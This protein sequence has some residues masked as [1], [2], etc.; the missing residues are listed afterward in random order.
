MIEALKQPGR[1]CWNEL[2][3]ND[4]AA[5]QQFYGEM[6]GWQME[7]TECGGVAYTTLKVNNDDIGGIMKT[8]AEAGEMPPM[9]GGYVTVDDVDESAANATQLGGSLCVPP[10]DMPGIGRFCVIKDPQGAMLSLFA[11]KK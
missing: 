1:F 4:V 6:F 5:A 11:F 9:W 2:L 7:D 8:P 3:T 10:Q